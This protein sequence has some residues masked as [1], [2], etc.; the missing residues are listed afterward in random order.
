[1]FDGDPLHFKSFMRAFEN[2]V[3]NK[4]TSHSDYLYFLEQ[5]TRGQPRDL[6]RSCHHLPPEPGY[7]R[8]KAL[9]TEHFGSE[10]KIS[11]AYM[12]KISN[13]SSIK[14][15]DVNA[16]QSFALFLRGCSN[17]VQHIKYMKEL[18]MPANLRII[19]MKLPYKLREK[20][21]NVACNI[22]EQTGSRAVFVDLVN[23]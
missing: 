4:T 16:L 17:L 1:M 8:A 10:H 9:L 23:F 11:A 7:Q 2:C 22:H 15:E 21:R 6:V 18:D 13:W 5:Y 20:W 12:D 14:P 19:V 3:E